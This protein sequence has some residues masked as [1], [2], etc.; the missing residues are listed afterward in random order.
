MQ[1]GFSGDLKCSKAPTPVL[2]TFI[3]VEF[4]SIEVIHLQRKQLI[5]LCNGSKKT[6][7]V[8]YSFSHDLRKRTIPFYRLDCPYPKAKDYLEL[9]RD[10]GLSKLQVRTWFGNY[11]KRQCKIHLCQA[12]ETAF[13]LFLTI[14]I[15]YLSRGKGW[16]E[17][18]QSGVPFRYECLFFLL[19][20][21][22]QFVSF[23]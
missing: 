8:L 15:S 4:F 16:P 20:S 7:V 17:S 18:V 19:L 1:I 3:F 21:S 13:D 5:G 14:I 12:R 2:L 22:K 6:N 9:C 10:S 11:R 23:L